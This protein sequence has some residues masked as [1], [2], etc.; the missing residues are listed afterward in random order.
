[1]DHEL[2]PVDSSLGW[3]IVLHVADALLRDPAMDIVGLQRR[4]LGM[5]VGDGPACDKWIF[6]DISWAPIN[7]VKKVND[8]G[9]GPPPSPHIVTAHRNNPQHRGIFSCRFACL[10]PQMTLTHWSILEPQLN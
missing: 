5:T 6:M 1:M 4:R 9:A 7:D 10:M 3:C 8:D 2:Q